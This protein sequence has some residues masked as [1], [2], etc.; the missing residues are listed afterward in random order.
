MKQRRIPKEFLGAFKKGHRKSAR[1]FIDDEFSKA[2]LERAQSGCEKSLQALEWIAKFNNEYYKAV[3]KRDDP[4]AFHKTKELI[5]ECDHRKYAMSMDVFL[6][7]N[8]K[9]QG[10]DF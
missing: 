2:L 1:E 10:S 9:K 8:K 3:I 7:L 6:N 4:K 5:S